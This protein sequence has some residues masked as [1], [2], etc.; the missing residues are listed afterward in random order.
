M[1]VTGNLCTGVGGKKKKKMMYVTTKNA[2]NQQNIFLRL[3]FTTFLK[4]NFFPPNTSVFF[5][6]VSPSSHIMHHSSLRVWQ[7]RDTALWGSCQGPTF[8]EENSD[9]DRCPGRGA[10]ET[11]EQAFTEGS[12]SLWHYYS[13]YEL[14]FWSLGFLSTSHSFTEEQEHTDTNNT[15]DSG[16]MILTN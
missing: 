15:C 14:K 13:M 5:F 7:T 9:F 6:H 1:Y 10:A 8:Q 12:T 11:E 16:R 4:V 2:G 3:S